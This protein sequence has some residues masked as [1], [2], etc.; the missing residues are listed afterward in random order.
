MWISVI[1]KWVRFGTSGSNVCGERPRPGHYVMDEEEKCVEDGT[2]CS[3]RGWSWRHT[4][5][6]EDEGGTCGQWD[7]Q[8]L[9]SMLS[10]LHD[11]GSG[12]WSLGWLLNLSKSEWPKEQMGPAEG[13]ILLAC[14]C[15]SCLTL[16]LPSAK[17]TGA[18]MGQLFTFT[19][20]ACW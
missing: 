9:A 8:R 14:F 17:C 1:Y 20:G 13:L 2:F 10:C 18:L 16:K 11:R 12:F 5:D 4:S 7:W 6:A 19:L 15:L 3:I